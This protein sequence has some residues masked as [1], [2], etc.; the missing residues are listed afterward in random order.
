MAENA[1]GNMPPKLKRVI[2]TAFEGVE[3]PPEL[4]VGIVS[5]VELCQLAM[6]DPAAIDQAIKSADFSEGKK[7]RTD[8]FSIWLA[9]DNKVFS[10]PVRNL[11]HKLYLRDRQDARVRL[12]VSAG[13]SDQ[14]RVIFVT[15]IFGGAIEADAIKAVVHVTNKHP[16]T[17][18]TVVNAQGAQ[19]RRVFWDIEGVAG[20]RG[21]MI[22]GPDNVESADAPRA[23][24]AFNLVGPKAS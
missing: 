10:F 23:I 7:D 12:L 16:L 11:T 6:P 1:P 17:G 13:E 24:T 9:L 2:E 5:L 3:A 22:T 21:M 4:S 8:E 20:I 15:T 18:A 14:G 19:L